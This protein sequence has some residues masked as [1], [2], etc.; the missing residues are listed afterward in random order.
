MSNNTKSNGG[1]STQDQ[2]QLS[3][4]KLIQDLDFSI[5]TLCN[6]LSTL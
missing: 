5:D 2:K 6:C 1:K 4:Q 3:Q